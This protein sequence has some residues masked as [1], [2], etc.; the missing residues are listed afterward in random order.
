MK[1]R[2]VFL[3]SLAKYALLGFAATLLLSAVEWADLNVQLTPVFES[4]SER[5]IL[6][7]YLSLNMLV[8]SVIGLLAGLAARAARFL[9]R[10]VQRPFARSGEPGPVH[11]LIAW[12]IVL[13][14]GSVV[15]NQQAH[16]FGY[17]MGMIREAQKIYFLR[18][19]LLDNETF[20]TY[21][22]VFFL[23]LA[24]AIT[25]ALSRASGGWRPWLRN[26]WLF[27]IAGLIAAVYYIDSRVEVQLYEPTLHRSMFLAG[28]ALAMAFVSSLY[29]SSPRV[30]SAWSDIRP[31]ARKLAACA[32]SAAFVAAVLFTFWRFDKDNNLKTQVFYR[33][34]QTKQHFRLAQW[35]LDFD[36]DGYSPYLGGGDA[37]DS[38]ADI[39]PGQTIA[40]GD[41]VDNNC[42][43][44][45]LTQQDIA[46]WEA[47]RD[48]LRPGPNPSGKRFN[49]IYIFIDALRADHLGAYGYHRNTSPNMDK[50]AARSS[51]FEYAYTPS[52][53][54]YA[55]LPKFMQSSYWDGHFETWTEVLARNGYRTVLFPSRITY[56]LKRHV[57]GMAES[58]SADKGGLPRAVDNVIATLEGGEQNRPF[59]AYLYVPDPH[60]PYV[61]HAEFNYGPAL[62]DLYDGEIAFTDYHLGRLFDWMERSGRIN[63]TMV[64]IM[65]DHAESLGERGVYKHSTQL[66]N[67][68]SRIPMIFYVPGLAPRRITDFVSSIDLGTTILD[69][70]GIE[71]PREYVGVSL[72]RLMRGEPF[73]HPPVYGEQVYTHDSRFVPPDKYV[74]PATKKF[75]VITQD[76]F[77]LIYNRDFYSFELFNLHD[78]PNE[79][80]N[81]FDEM[82]AKADQLK[83]LVGRFVDITIASRPSDAEEVWV[84]P[85]RKRK[86]FG[87]D[88]EDDADD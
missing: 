68:Q 48:A 8:G 2:S 77:K 44:G 15:L 43:G 39:N 61:E 86:K 6:T 3:I 32:L 20:F 75:M 29:L 73:T 1:D 88:A 38:R 84:L 74:H 42:I 31:Q 23:L 28:M 11:R 57:K 36:R 17:V 72:L 25:W 70:V 66:Y 83:R 59:C 55:A 27:G 37:D 49:L 14:L 81:L 53:F 63:D 69:T 65:A 30:R 56:T 50:L 51:V 71:P 4:A 40:V 41:G 9:K 7:S 12:L 58:V 64:V 52:P 18:R 45:D 5:L 60:L 19:P 67:E 78:D 21:V 24:C 16:V 13:T 10:H 62:E 33:T 80:R 34:T 82:P 47:R 87:L 46:E 35:A 26:A 54:T 79:L 22:V 76:G 85:E